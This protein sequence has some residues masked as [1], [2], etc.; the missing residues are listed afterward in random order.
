[1]DSPANTMDSSDKGC[2]LILETNSRKRSAP[3]SGIGIS[4]SSKGLGRTMGRALDLLRRKGEYAFSFEFLDNIHLANDGKACSR[5]H[6][7]ICLAGDL[8]FPEKIFVGNDIY[9]S[10]YRYNVLVR[11]LIFSRLF[12]EAM[13]FS[14]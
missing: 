14:C 8:S 10:V 2:R 11:A 9:E 1:M 4:L 12:G 7:E 5:L 13:H 6:C 3:S